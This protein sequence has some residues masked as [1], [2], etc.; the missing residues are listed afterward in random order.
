MT[1]AVREQQQNLR[2]QNDLL[3]CWHEFP[4]TLSVHACVAK[5]LAMNV[6]KL[7]RHD[8]TDNV[9]RFL[10]STEPKLYVLAPYIYMIQTASGERAY[11]PYTAC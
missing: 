11:I 9:R 4:F 1:Y 2:G 7:D 3:V 10:S 6:D 5:V 8:A